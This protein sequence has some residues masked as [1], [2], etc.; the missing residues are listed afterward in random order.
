M[1]L[2]TYIELTFIS[3]M[4]ALLYCIYSALFNKIT[5]T[6]S[7]KRSSKNN[8]KLT[9]SPHLV[10]TAADIKNR[11]IF[12]IGDVH[13]CLDEF[14]ELLRLAKTE[15][16]GKTLLPIFVGDL[17]NKGPHN[18]STI[19]RIRAENGYAVRGNHDEAVIKQCLSRQERA[20]YIVPD[21]YK[22][23]TELV[24]DDI[25]FLQELPYTIHIPSKNSVIVHGGLVPGTP[26]EEQDYT[27][28]ITMR[29]LFKDGDTL[30]ASANRLIGKPWA[31]LWQ[32]PEHVYFG[33]DAARKLQ[34][35]SYA[36]GLD[37]GCLYGN[38]LTGIF[39]DSQKMIHVKAKRVYVS[40]E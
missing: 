33:H 27:N 22:W 3:V 30:T 26:L 9:K 31:S 23:I 17:A 36:T 28:F 29:S 1:L 24:A 38:C 25:R 18:V 4:A 8:I 20:D 11:E 34:Q 5:E 35:Y 19:R 15:L 12:I 37:T 16:K 6:A 13:G 14:N 7:Y 40:P 39:L 32:G 2:Y 21:K 10:L